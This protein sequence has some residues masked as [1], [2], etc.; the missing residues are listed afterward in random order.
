[1]DYP[2][3]TPHRR[4]GSLPARI[5]LFVI[6]LIMRAVRGRPPM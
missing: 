3:K 2:D 4:T 6:S 1:M 5:V